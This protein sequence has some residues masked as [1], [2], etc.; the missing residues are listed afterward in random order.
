LRSGFDQLGAFEQWSVLSD[1][2]HS[3]QIYNERVATFLV[4]LRRKSARIWAGQLFTIE[5]VAQI[6]DYKIM[7]T[8]D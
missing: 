5:I 7:T 2:S 6:Q 8:I 3:P 1:C 4:N